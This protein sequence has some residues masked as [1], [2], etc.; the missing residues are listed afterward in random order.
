MG[1]TTET[2]GDLLTGFT[3]DLDD[4]TLIAQFTDPLSDPAAILGNA[5]TRALYDLG[6]YQRTAV[7]A[8]ASPPGVYMLARETHVSDLAAAPDPG[9]PQTTRYQY[10]FAYSDGFG[11][12]IQR[13]AQVGTGPGHRWWSA[14]IATLGRVRLDNLQR[15][16]TARSE[17]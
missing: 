3:A 10:H 13:K 11:R 2:A 9:A 12:E 16:G 1:K 7:A 17:I 5:T 15:R 8:Q 4:A 6:A 14:S